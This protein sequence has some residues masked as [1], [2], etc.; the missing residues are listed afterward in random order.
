[1]LHII[2][3]ISEKHAFMNKFGPMNHKVFSI[4]YK[5][6]LFQTRQTN[7]KIFFYKALRHYDIS[8]CQ[9]ILLVIITLQSQN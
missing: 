8:K 4:K 7:I 2:Y 1:M 6:N 9:N 5:N 3:R